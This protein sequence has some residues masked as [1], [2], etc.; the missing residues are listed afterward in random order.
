MPP[1]RR[2]GQ[3]FR[4]ARA[5][6]PT[7]RAAGG[8]LCRP[9]ET[10]LAQSG[11]DG[12]PRLVVNTATG[13]IAQRM[14]Y[15]EYGKVANDTNPGFQPFGFAG[16]IYDRDMGLVRFGAR[17]YDAGSG[18]WTVKD[19]IGFDGEDSNLYAYVGN[20]PVNLVDPAGLCY[21]YADLAIDVG[22]LAIGGVSLKVGYFLVV[23]GLERIA[24]KRLAAQVL[25][26]GAAK[27]A[28]EASSL[29]N[30]ARLRGQLAGQEIA[31]GHAFEKHVL[32]QGEFKGL[33]IRTREQFANH[34]ENV[35]NNPT[36][37]RQ[38][39]GG[40]SAYWQESSGTV[41]IRNPRAADGGTAFQPTN[42]R[43]YFDGL[44]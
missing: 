9:G 34:I 17:D 32:N 19:P 4:A 21:S 22:S 29:A 3:A 12:S 1:H 28:G 20:D 36:A 26:R 42:G 24:A 13:A 6:S 27:G 40:R 10:P 14:D 30:A 25:S 11:L 41:V 39:S 38:L 16:G 44:R 15:D 43:A 37:S 8:G 5:V 2:Q 35:V 18:R 31:G 23:K 33:G 7:F